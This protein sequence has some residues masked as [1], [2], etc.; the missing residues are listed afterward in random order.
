VLSVVEY[1]QVLEQGGGQIQAGA[2][3][4]AVERFQVSHTTAKKWAGR[5]RL[6]AEF[7]VRTP[8]G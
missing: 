3:P 7:G 5:Y 8:P 4:A 6:H 1:L 2:Q